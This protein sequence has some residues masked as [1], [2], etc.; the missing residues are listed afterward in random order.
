[1]AYNSIKKRSFL[2]LV[3]HFTTFAV[4]YYHGDMECIKI[5]DDIKSDP[6]PVVSLIRWSNIGEEVSLNLADYL[7]TRIGKDDTVSEITSKFDI[8]IL[9]SKS[10]PA[11]SSNVSTSPC[12]SSQFSLDNKLKASLDSWSS[13]K[14]DLFRVDLVSDSGRVSSS[15]QGEQLSKVYSGQL[16]GDSSQSP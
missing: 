1:M 16:V 14:H 8:H 5:S 9:F 12:P 10:L 7:V 4:I 11:S 15:G 3:E 6:R 13:K 2:S